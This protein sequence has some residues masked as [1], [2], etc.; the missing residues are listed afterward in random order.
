MISSHIHRIGIKNIVSIWEDF[1][2]FSWKV[3]PDSFDPM[4]FNMP[5]FLVLCYLLYHVKFIPLSWGC[6][7]TISSYVTPSSFCLQSILASGS[8]PISLLFSGQ[9][10]RVSASASVLPMNI[11][12]WF[13]LGLTRLIFLQCKGLSR[14]FSSTMIRKHH[15]FNTQTSLWS[16][17]YICTWLLKNP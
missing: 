13:P 14:V 7:L 6:H 16:N 12:G 3:V 17:S 11:Q 8:F 1:F 9:I 2:L 5:G 15:F 4:D 10:I